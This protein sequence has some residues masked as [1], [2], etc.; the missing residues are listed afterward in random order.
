A[1]EVL[2]EA[3]KW[4]W[5]LAVAAAVKGGEGDGDPW[6][7]EDGG[8]SGAAEAE[9]VVPLVRPEDDFLAPVRPRTVKKPVLPDERPAAVPS[10]KVAH[11]GASYV[12]TPEDHKEI[13][14]RAIAVEVAKAEA[15]RRVLEDLSYPPELDD[16]DD[17][18]F[19]ESDDDDEDA[20]GEGGEGTAET[21]GDGGPLKKR[22]VD[23]VRKTTSQRNRE[24]ARAKKE[25]ELAIARATKNMF[26][27]INNI[28][29]IRKRVERAETAAAAAREK[30][31]A[32][33]ASEKP[34]EKRRLGPH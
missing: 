17:E 3:K 6:G 27:Q 8:S 26:K 33:A 11:P 5:A 2:A 12:P 14:D 21:T 24:S 30:Q 18:A 15:E 10:V 20:N 25:R 19:F 28:G 23:G 7:D 22:R 29:A 31:A 9:A 4:Q 13:L 16:L 34:T 1:G 32:A